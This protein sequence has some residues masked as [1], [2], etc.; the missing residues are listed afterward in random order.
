MPGVGDIVDFFLKL[1]GPYKWYVISGF[2]LILTAVIT[3]FIFK[4]LK[5]FLIIIAAVVVGFTI[6]SYL[7][8]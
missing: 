3:R 6:V 5:W 4:T 8:A 2:L 1:E 7:I